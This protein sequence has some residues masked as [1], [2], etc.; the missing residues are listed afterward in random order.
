MSTTPPRP[1]STEPVSSISSL[2]PEPESDS[3][4]QSEPEVIE[5]TEST[6]SSGLESTDNVD[7]PLYTA[8]V[9]INLVADTDAQAEDEQPVT[10]SLP[11]ELSPVSPVPLHVPEPSK[12]PL[13]LDPALS[14]TIPNEEQIPSDIGSA[15]SDPSLAGDRIIAQ[16]AGL[17]GDQVTSDEITNA[18]V[19]DIHAVE[20]TD[21]VM[22]QTGS[23]E[24]ENPFT[25]MQDAPPPG[26]DANLASV[27]ATMT[28]MPPITAEFTVEPQ[29]ASASILKDDN[30]LSEPA[31]ASHSV[32]L[33][34]LL[35]TMVNQNQPMPDINGPGG[36]SHTGLS[37]VTQPNH[38]DG[39]AVSQPL[40]SPSALPQAQSYPPL[41]PGPNTLPAL[42][43]QASP[44]SI[45]HP[46]NL[47]HPLPENPTTL[48]YAEGDEG[49]TS[50]TADEEKAYDNFLN[51]ERDYVA[52][53]EWSRF[54]NGS[55]LFIGNLS[56]ER[57][58]K[59]D[60]YRV[61]AKH[62]KLAQISI[63]QAFG[64]VQFFD[65]SACTKALREEQGTPVRGRKMHL[66]IS[67]PQRNSRNSESQASSRAG[68]ARRSR[69][70]EEPISPRNRGSSYRG[71]AFGDRDRE[72]RNSRENGL[73]GRDEY[74][75]GDRRMS[76]PRSQYGR[77][78]DDYYP[79]RD[80][81]D[82]DRSRSP[83]RRYRSPTPPPHRASFDRPRSPVQAIDALFVVFDELDPGYI[84][85]VDNI[86]RDR[87][88]RT[89]VLHMT[90][91]IHLETY[92][93]RQ[94]VEGCQAVVFLTRATQ[95]ANKVSIQIF[96]GG[97]N[98]GQ[99]D[100]YDMVNPDAAAE[101]VRR[102]CAAPSPQYNVPN[103]YPNAQYQ[104]Q[105][106]HS[107]YMPSTQAP[108]YPVNLPPQPAPALPAP[109]SQ[110]N[111]T[112][113]LQNLDPATLQTLLAQ[114]Q[115]Q[116]QQPGA[117][118]A[119]QNSYM[120][121]AAQQIQKPADLA[122]LLGAAQAQQAYGSVPSGIVPDYQNPALVGLLNGL[123][124]R[125]AQ[126]PQTNQQVQNIMSQLTGQWSGGR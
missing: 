36:I 87:R 67:K 98:S 96:K 90:P 75:P 89:D 64:F 58:S 10:T 106:S 66:E 46:T 61:F 117:T 100:E 1:G 83:Q 30:A 48:S 101:L 50:F 94:V 24:S 70:P 34:A 108:M 63:K 102:A 59:R 91:R 73:R 107:G 80:F 92:I 4:K 42:P 72:A 99:Y 81:R 51:I 60:I 39:A 37:V 119:V 18:P 43:V 28:D 52:K 17:A 6:S 2:T 14:R 76:S 109:L 44:V 11:K 45:S 86:F 56:S 47:R 53:G 38:L 79:S 55:R 69:T 33:Q 95:Q 112:G 23:S 93:K 26:T 7:E 104:G 25:I 125:N 97:S 54:P 41:K 111:L 19:P 49:E 29:P 118:A 16:E 78:R 103:G 15:L 5:P 35:A 122:A 113:I 84:K 40:A 3:E 57:V 21:Q 65:A 22:H 27:D 32:N 8:T 20:T 120:Q 62:G 114:L 12:I 121:P 116:Q 124:Q 123:N 68:P 74:R 13:L 126:Q 71:A 85:Y 77:E 82:R 88:L 105:Q 115:S 31:P 110:A 9:D